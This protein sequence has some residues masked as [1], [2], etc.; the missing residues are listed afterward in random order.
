[1]LLVL[2]STVFLGSEFVALASCQSLWFNLGKF[3]V[4][5]VLDE[6]AMEQALV[7]FSVSHANHP[8]TIVPYPPRAA[9]LGVR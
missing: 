4:K 8:S 6:V 2:A 9:P 7:S 1:M 5:F 3:Q